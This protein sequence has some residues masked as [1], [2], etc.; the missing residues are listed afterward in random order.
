M[1]LYHEVAVVK[2]GNKRVGWLLK[3]GPVQAQPA[4]LVF[5]YGR[6]VQITC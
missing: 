3:E 1:K 4:D 5:C 2:D 6:R